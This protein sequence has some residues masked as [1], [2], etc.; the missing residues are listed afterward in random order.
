M[1]VVRRRW[2]DEVWGGGGE[3]EGGPRAGRQ[4][5]TRTVVC[6]RSCKV[7]HLSV[8]FFPSPSE[9]IPGRLCMFPGSFDMKHFCTL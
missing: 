9:A 6:N 7:F 8:L 5:D 3:E 1:A 2:P 4:A